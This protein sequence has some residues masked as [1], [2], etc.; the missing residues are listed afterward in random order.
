MKRLLG[1][2]TL[3][4]CL[5]SIVGCNA[6]GGDKRDLPT[7]DRISSVESSS[8]SG[9][10]SESSVSER[11]GDSSLNDYSDDASEEN[12]GTGIFDDD[13]WSERR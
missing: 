8:F 11:V 2:I 4:V 9:A 6:W 12:S 10:T 1:L 7:N 3:L 13:Y 5:V